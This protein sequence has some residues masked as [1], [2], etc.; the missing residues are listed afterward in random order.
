VRVRLAPFVRLEARRSLLRATLP[1]LILGAIAAWTPES[2]DP[3]PG[4]ARHRIWMIGLLV[5]LPLAIGLAAD[6]MTRIRRGE[7]EWLSSRP[8]APLAVIFASWFG[9]WLAA[10]AALVLLVVLTTTATTERKVPVL[11]R[12][13]VN[14]HMIRIPAGAT[15]QAQLAGYEQG[16][17]VRVRVGPI[18][19]G[20]SPTTTCAVSVTRGG[21]TATHEERL[22]A[23]TWVEAPIPG[24]DDVPVLTITNT[25]V[26]DLAWM[27]GTSIELYGVDGLASAVSMDLALRAAMLLAA[28]LALAAGLGAWVTTGS[29]TGV[30]LCLLL[31]TTQSPAFDVFGLSAAFESAAQ[32]RL[33]RDLGVP[34]YVI[35]LALTLLGLAL[36]RLGWHGKRVDA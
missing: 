27:D 23:R 5:L 31:M 33:P 18:L 13:G 26:G 16:T 30:V 25:G 10:C 17:S 7:G 3:S 28:A 20:D 21:T 35:A 8:V 1:T 15:E 4:A 24:G 11:I 36:G 34:P 19:G 22:V 12:Q 6:R 9:T 29:A 32:E 14:A 2:A